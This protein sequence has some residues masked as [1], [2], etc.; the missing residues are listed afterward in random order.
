MT[1]PR[2]GW[3]RGGGNRLRGSTTLVC[4][5]TSPAMW[6]QWRR[7]LPS[8]C[9]PSM[10][11]RHR[12]RRT[13]RTGLLPRGQTLLEQLLHQCYAHLPPPLPSTTPKHPNHDQQPRILLL[14]FFH[15]PRPLAPP[16]GELVYPQA[17]ALAAPAPAARRG[18]GR[19]RPQGVTRASASTG[20]SGRVA[21]PPAR[22]LVPREHEQYMGATA[23]CR[24]QCIVSVGGGRKLMGG[25]RLW[26]LSSREAHD[27]QWPRHEG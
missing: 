19:G 5:R 22:T 27:A 2:D 3:Q 18:R 12:T 6:H 15:T 14:L 17:L 10:S 21:R 11:A 1:H 8:S 7:H 4:A 13:D 24:R 9:R 25:G 26:L 16:P 20:T 23:A